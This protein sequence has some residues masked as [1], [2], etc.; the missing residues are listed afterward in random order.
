MNTKLQTETAGEIAVFGSG[1]IFGIGA[2][3][4]KFAVGY[5]DGI[6][7]SLIRFI[8]GL[9]AGVILLLLIRKRLPRLNDKKTLVIRG[10]S[11]A[12]AMTTYFISVQYTTAGRATLLNSTYGIFSAIFGALFFKEKIN[13]AT[14]VGI[15]LS[16]G[17]MVFIFME[18]GKFSVIGDVIGL[19]SG[20]I[21][22]FSLHFISK[23]R[24]TN[25]S[26][27]VYLSACVFGILATS[28]SAGKVTTVSGAQFGFLILIGVLIF[29]AHVILNYGMKYVPPTKSAVIT[30]LK[31]PLTVLFG[32]LILGEDITPRFLIGT[33]LIVS[34]LIL[35][36]AIKKRQPSPAV[37]EQKE[38]V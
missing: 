6:F 7:I 27:V 22:G 36:S 19:I 31:V 17:G 9:A 26:I 23:A 24:Q 38:K 28:F 35:N 14:L 10:I 12:L 1:V 25:D 11:G 20:V 30:Y 34:G 21:A 16:F 29:A 15:F 3:M 2:V 4:I 33:S 13:W 8:S 18:S 32:Y 37:E 5:A